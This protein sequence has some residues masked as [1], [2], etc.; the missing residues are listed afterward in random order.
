[1]WIVGAGVG[2]AKWIDD[3]SAYALAALIASRSVQSAVPQTPSSWSSAVLTVNVGPVCC[4]SAA[5]AG[6]QAGY[7]SWVPFVKRRVR[8]LPSEFIVKTSKFCVPP[9]LKT[10]ASFVPSGD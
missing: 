6:A 1:G 9:G 3:A 10:N 2:I 5:E 8:S 7:P 4:G